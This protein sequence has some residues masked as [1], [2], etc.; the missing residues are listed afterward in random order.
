MS[1]NSGDCLWP[2]S[3]TSGRFSYEGQF[4][5]MT[6]LCLPNH[7]WPSHV[8][9]KPMATPYDS[10]RWWSSPAGGVPAASSLTSQPLMANGMERAH[11][12]NYWPTNQYYGCARPSVNDLPASNPAASPF[13]SQFSTTYPLTSPAAPPSTAAAFGTGSSLAAAA[14]CQFYGAPSHPSSSPRCST[15]QLYCGGSDGCPSLGST[16]SPVADRGYFKT[17]ADSCGQYLIHFHLHSTHTDKPSA[18]CVYYCDTRAL[19]LTTRFLDMS[20]LW[21]S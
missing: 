5:A 19:L 16:P 3:K 15:Q 10:S 8:D 13:Y 14:A 6:S 7:C 11:Y 17:A 20:I 21:P 4:S 18:Q 12:P 1:C 2:R 9:V